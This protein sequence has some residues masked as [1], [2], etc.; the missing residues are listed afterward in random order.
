MVLA[1]HPFHHARMLDQVAFDIAEH[2]R[3]MVTRRQLREAGLTQREVEYLVRSR[4][5]TVETDTVLRRAGSTRAPD[6]FVMLA[7]LDA[8]PRAA[9]SH[10]TGARLFGRTGCPLRPVTV[11]RT[12]SSRR[13]TPLARVHKVRDLPPE[14]V[15]VLNGIPVVRP[16]LLALQLFAVCT[17]G[18]AERLTDGL[19]SDRLL[20]GASIQ[21]FLGEFGSVQGRN[22]AA[23]LREYLDQRGPDYIPPASGLES[24]FMELMDEAGV[25]VR[26]QVDSGGEHWTGRVDFRHPTRP[27]IVEVQSEKY[28]SAL[29]DRESD[30][31]RIKRLER[32]GFTVFE[33]TDTLIWTSPAET[34]RRVR[35]A[36]AT[37]R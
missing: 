13:S 22:G 30:V 28:H 27:L 11:V 32:D 15:T 2:Q 23:G 14:W 18:R 33:I 34:V 7:V 4:H 26:R 5:W 35:A 21:R 25:P 16:E 6:D 12:S 3:G 8:G 20:S 31:L 19:W 29:C 10:L 36:L 24:R 1:R 17:F 37:L 9:T